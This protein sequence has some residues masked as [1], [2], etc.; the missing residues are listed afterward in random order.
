MMENYQKAAMC[1]NNIITLQCILK[2]EACTG[3]CASEAET[4][5]KE[6]ERGKEGRR[7]VC[8]L[9]ENNKGQQGIMERFL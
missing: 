5:Q 9:E 7:R 1:L 6:R 3:V 4:L 2:T 8:L